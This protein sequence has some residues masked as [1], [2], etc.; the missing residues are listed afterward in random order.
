MRR[1][2]P[3]TNRLSTALA[4]LHSKLL[5]L[6][7]MDD[8]DRKLVRQLTE[9]QA[10]AGKAFEAARVALDAALEKAAAYDNRA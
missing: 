2:R 3:P 1:V 7:S 10:A 9:D 4:A 8:A 6:P 5:V